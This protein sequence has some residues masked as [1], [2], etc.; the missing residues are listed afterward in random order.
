MLCQTIFIFYY[1]AFFCLLLSLQVRSHRG[2]IGTSK[3][4]RI[5]RKKKKNCET[6]S[7]A[8]IVPDEAYNCVN[9]CISEICYDSV[10]KMEPLED[11]EIDVARNRQ[12]IFCV[13]NEI[14]ENLIQ[15]N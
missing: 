14:R 9:Q 1:C 10:Y 13:R 5:W 12:F 8:E 4:D 6:S 3:Y 2:N 11:G 7:C 15:K